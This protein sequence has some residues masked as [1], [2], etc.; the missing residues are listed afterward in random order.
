M[1]AYAGDQSKPDALRKRAAQLLQ[2][3]EYVSSAAA[4]R[5]LQEA[6]Q[7]AEA[8]QPDSAANDSKLPDINR[9]PACTMALGASC[10]AAADGLA[11]KEQCT[12][13]P[14]A[15]LTSSSAQSRA[16]PS[17]GTVVWAREKGWPHWPAVVITKE[18]SRGLCNIRKPLHCVR[19]R[20][21]IYPLGSL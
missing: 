21:L 6:E 4:K 10:T 19:R 17:L 13:Q 3:A 20:A 8:P 18:P 7:I 14:P 9:A 11:E 12:A 16:R 2:I 15:R 1:V 5:S